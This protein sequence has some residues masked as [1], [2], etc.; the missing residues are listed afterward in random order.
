MDHYGLEHTR[1]KIDH[2]AEAMPRGAGFEIVSHPEAE[3]FI[4]RRR[5]GGGALA[6]DR[7]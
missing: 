4:C 1:R 7:P 6:E 2:S 3:V 5:E